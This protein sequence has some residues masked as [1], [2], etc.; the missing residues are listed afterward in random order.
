MGALDFLFEGKPPPST[1]TYGTTTTDMPKWLSDY[2]Q[3]LIGRAN[4]IA[5]EDYQTYTGPRLAGLTPDQE[6][7][8]AI[9]RQAS[10]NYN[11]LM[12]SATNAAQGALT[13]TAPY[14]A[15]AGQTFPQQV[16]AYMNP[17]IENVV[18]RAGT[19]A[20]R[21]LNEKFLPSV[22]RTFGAA[23]ATPRSTEMRRTV[24]Q[25]VRDLTEGLH[26]Q[27]LAA[28]AEGYGQAGT[29]FNQD[30]TRMGGLAQLVNSMGLNTAQTQGALAETGQN[31]AFRDAAAQ[32]AVG[33][34]LQQDQQR[35]LDLAY[36]DFANQRDYPKEQAEWLSNIIRGTP[37]ASTTTTQQTGPAN[38]YQPSPLAQI[39]SL[40]TG[41]KGIWDIFKKSARGGPI[42]A[43][44]KAGGR[45]KRRSV[46]RRGALQYA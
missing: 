33:E 23:G 45:V 41:I 38:A 9:T 16:D 31:L 34:A 43:G 44:Y 37:H 46:K 42:R 25:G 5:G 21:Q 2:T 1:T 20:E 26:E 40:A 30:A 4:A 14:V 18:N 13:A 17:Y 29:L 22:Y 32:S 35:S 36:E 12:T 3:G 39:G 19:L 6:R 7:A 28:L 10:G 24:D 8:A 27:S 11:P 15:A